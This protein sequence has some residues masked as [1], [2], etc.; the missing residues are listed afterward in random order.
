[1]E[2]KTFFTGCA[3][4]LL[5]FFSGCAKIPGPFESL[6]DFEESFIK[7]KSSP[8][9]PA[10]KLLT[11]ER[12]V[13]TALLNNPTNLAAAQAVQAAKY[14]YFRA[15][16]AYAPEINLSA[17]PQHTLS[18]GWDL[19]NPPEGVMKRNDHFVASG[20]IQATWLLFDGFAR[21][22]E[23]LIAYDEYSKSRA[24]GKNVRRLLERAVAYAYYDM[25]QAGEEIIIYEED[26]AFQQSA[27]TQEEERFR[28][29]HV[30]K[31]SV[32]NF[33]ILAARADGRISNARFRR[34]TAFHALCAL[35]GCD[36]RELTEYVALEK[37]SFEILPFIKDDLFYLELAIINRPDLVMEKIA[38]TVAFR[39]RQKV[40]AD[41]MPEFRLFS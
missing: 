39:S 3:A 17:S 33:R 9:L 2:I 10:E 23:S 19:K 20:T 13:K 26:L 15:L 18:R 41:F 29:G 16:S 40:Y 12:A 5:V 14:G 37:I 6:A 21:E 4:V 35:M 8:L 25:Y 11:L 34:Q 31:A 28:N 32:L 36:E 38:L 7:K 1:M 27:L 24:A 30:S 22:L